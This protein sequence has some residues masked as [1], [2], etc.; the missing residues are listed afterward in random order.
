MGKLGLLVACV[1][2]P[3][4]PGCLCGGSAEAAV[5]GC[6]EA[7]G[8]GANIGIPGD[9]TVTGPLVDGADFQAVTPL[10]DTQAHSFT[11][12][13]GEALGRVRVSWGSEGTDLDAAL[14]GEEVTVE[15]IQTNP[16]AHGASFVVRDEGGLVLAVNG[17][18][19][20]RQIDDT[21][22]E[23]GGFR[24]LALT[25]CGSV[26][27]TGVRVSNGSVDRDLNTGEPAT[28][29]VGDSDVL[30]HP[31]VALR[32]GAEWQCTDSSDTLNW[33]MVRVAR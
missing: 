18:N 26:T 12:D 1:V 4:L 16:W 25:A 11:I 30:F 24:A 10:C 19:S 2:I 7:E 8:E 17:A 15:Q 23:H 14:M 28:L 21:T 33:A 32:L 5:S 3:F 27:A 6:V 22:I 29:T 9:E 13:G 31:F 20:I